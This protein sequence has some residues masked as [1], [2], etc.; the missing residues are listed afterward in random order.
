MTKAMLAARGGIS[1]G[2]RVSAVNPATMPRAT[3]LT[4]VSTT[5]TRSLCLG[6]AELTYQRV[7]LGAG[8]S[9]CVTKTSRMG[10]TIPEKVRLQV[11]L[12]ATF[13]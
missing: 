10:Q 1:Q 2:S 13:A 4:I 11:Y 8:A 6:G 7:P 5:I 3:R 12:K 9:V